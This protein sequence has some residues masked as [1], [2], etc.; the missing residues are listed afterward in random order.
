MKPTRSTNLWSQTLSY[1]LSIFFK[2]LLLRVFSQTFLV[3]GSSSVKK[4]K[5]FNTLFSLLRYVKCELNFCVV[6]FEF[7]TFFLFFFHFSLS[8]FLYQKRWIIIFSFNSQSHSIL[9]LPP[10]E[11]KRG[12]LRKNKVVFFHWK[13][14]HCVCVWK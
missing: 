14:K 4:T 11:K 3:A 8:I 1:S 5:W 9:K 6:M 7:R 12:Q 2:I 10:F 13:K